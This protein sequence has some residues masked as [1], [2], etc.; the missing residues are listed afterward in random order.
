MTEL[1]RSEQ[2]GYEVEKERV[3]ST[4]A[5]KKY[6]LVEILEMADDLRLRTLKI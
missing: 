6:G 4:L 3:E 2:K 1:L 5:P